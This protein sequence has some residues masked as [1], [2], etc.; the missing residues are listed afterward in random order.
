MSLVTASAV[1]SVN[2]EPPTFPH[3]VN[4]CCNITP[5]L[6]SHC[7]VAKNIGCKKE[8]LFVQV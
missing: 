5:C 2:V 3:K 1:T 7:F 6:P 4:I 8:Y